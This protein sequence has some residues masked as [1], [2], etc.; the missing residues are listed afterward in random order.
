M[1]VR[2]DVEREEDGRWIGEAVDLPGAM[3]YGATKKEA[4]AQARALAL[5]AIAERL[6]R[7]EE[8]PIW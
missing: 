8:Y 4:E 5:R 7:G 1:T 3:V 2:I 6:E